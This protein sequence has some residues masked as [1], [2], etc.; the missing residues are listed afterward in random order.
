MA[1]VFS[2]V[3]CAHHRAG[4]FP[5]ELVVVGRALGVVPHPDVGFL[6]QS[7]GRSAKVHGPPA[8]VAAN[9][10]KIGSM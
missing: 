8:C 4:Y 2:G 7:T 6:K 10:K 9:A 1:G 3:G 5:V